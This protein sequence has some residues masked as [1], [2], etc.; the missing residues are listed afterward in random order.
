M[1]VS[2]PQSLTN[3]ELEQELAAQAAHLD[4]GLCR[5]IELAGECERRLDWAGDGTTFAA[6]LAWRCSLLPRQAREHE[7]IAARLNELPLV[8]AAFA[9]GELSYAKV[10]TLVRVA[11]A[12]NEA[13]LIELA[14]VMTASQLQRAVA[15]YERVTREDAAEQQE[16][17]FVDWFWTEDG[18]LSLRA[19]L[20]A[21]EG[22]LVLRALEAGRAALRERRV[23]TSPDRVEAPVTNAEAFLAMADIALA[24]DGKRSG[25][26]RHQIV[27]HVDAQVLADDADGRCELVDGRP[28]A[29]E[30]ARRLA[31][32]ASL[33]ELHER[34]GH[35]LSLGR[36]RRTVSPAL[37]RALH[38]RDRGCR[39]PG[40]DR[41]RFV[42]AHH[43]KH[44]SQG[45]ETNLDNL[46]TL[47]RRHHR[48]VH[49]RGYSVKLGDDGEVQFTN[50]HGIAIPSAP[51][52]PPSHRA[53]LP[54]QHRRR[55]LPIDSRT[56]RNGTGDRMELAYAVAAISSSTVA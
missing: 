1:F 26:E 16:Q 27:V 46:L 49:E 36:K 56:C 31:C 35:V 18:S 22:A 34:D 12:G 42:D 10:G 29:A 32:D 2:D 9:R 15:A 53:A 3:D 20:P 21:E 4:A 43:V 50:Q 44:W 40:C 28:L 45:G 8:H 14:E 11:D 19:R 39:F 41:T 5:L 6:W 47:C 37:R 33:V 38:T 13:K 48:L 23:E 7:R 25:G 55:R 24:S 17:E 54:E 52:S 30:T 51:R